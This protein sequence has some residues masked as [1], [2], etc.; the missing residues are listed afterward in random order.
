[1]V[2]RHAVLLV[3]GQ[4]SRSHS[5]RVQKYMLCSVGFIIHDSRQIIAAYTSDLWQLIEN[6]VTSTAVLTLDIGRG[7]CKSE[8]IVTFLSF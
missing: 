1:M 6:I 3:A 8:G 7:E 4:R 5:H 2:S